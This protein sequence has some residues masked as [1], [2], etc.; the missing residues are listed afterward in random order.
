MIKPAI[1]LDRDGTINKD[2]GYVHKI[3]DFE[4]IDGAREAIKLF[5]DKGYYVFITTNQSGIGRGFYSIEDVKILHKYISKD[6]SLI[7]AKIDDFFFSPY[8]YTDKLNR[9]DHIK[10]LRKPNTGMLEWASSKWPINKEKSFLIG[11]SSIDIDCAK[12]FG[13]K[14]FLFNEKNLLKFVEKILI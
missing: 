14:G 6:L 12:N 3:Q 4:W 2:K 13:I 8:H 7:N 1:F 10:N 9:F 5:N 11:D